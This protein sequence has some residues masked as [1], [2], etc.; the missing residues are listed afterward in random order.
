LN[1]SRLTPSRT[2]QHPGQHHLQTLDN[3][4]Y[5]VLARLQNTISDLTG[6]FWSS[7]GAQTIFLPV[8][9]GSISSP[10]GLGSDSLPVEVDILGARTYLAD[11]MQF[12]LEYGCRL[13][14][15][16]CFYIMPAFR[17]EPVDATHLC[18]F[19]HSEAEIIGGLDDVIKVVEAYLVHLAHG[20]LERNE[21]DITRIT[22][23]T[24]HLVGLAE[25]S[26]FRRITFG[27]AWEI[28]DGA[29]V[30]HSGGWRS[31][32]RESERLIMDKLGPFTWVT[33][34][35]HLAVP[36]YQAFSDNETTALNGDLLFGLGEIVGA[37]ERHV[38]SSD[39]RRAMERHR[40]DD[41]PYRWYMEMRDHRPLQT[42]GFGLGLERFLLWVLDHDDIRDMQLLPRENG[43]CITP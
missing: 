25:G 33:H 21:G 14:D 18:Q 26:V 16:D 9:T 2:W 41:A 17:G 40:V 38:T 6:S 15:T 42:A 7:R 3:P 4:W 27:E 31:L 37:G 36:F 22:G 28:L 30:Y 19:F 10:M 24:D 1:S 11:S 29:G 32:S 39:V 34:W 12:M 13:I 5:R 23:R 43:V 20:L 8:T 35:D